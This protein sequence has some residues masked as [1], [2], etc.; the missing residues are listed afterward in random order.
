MTLEKEHD[1]MRFTT[2][3][4]PYIEGSLVT[5]PPPYETPDYRVEE[6]I[7][8]PK[9]TYFYA[10]KQRPYRLSPH[11]KTTTRWY[12][13]NMNFAGCYCTTVYKRLIPL[14]GCAVI[15]TRHILTTATSTHLILKDRYDYETLENI[16][17][18]WYDT[19][20]DNFNSSMYLSPARIHYHPLWHRP[21]HV[22]RSH[23]FS[24]TFDLAVWAATYNVYGWYFMKG[25]TTTCLRASSHSR[26]HGSPIPSNEL[27]IIVGYQYMWA[28]KHKPMPWFKYAILTRYTTSPCPKTE[29][30]WFICLYGDWARYGIEGG[31]ALHRS[32]QGRSWRHDG[33]VAMGAFSMRLRSIE[34]TH[35]FTILDNWAVLD[36]LYDAYESSFPYAW[37]DGRF[38]DT[39]HYAPV[40]KSGF[41]VPRRYPQGEEHLYVPET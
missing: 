22:N 39:K 15:T 28:F 13:D 29:W 31:A 32:F 26:D 24:F 2:T 34:M 18:A 14:A 41:Y 9:R 7:F 30:G 38:E 1:P 37:L 17:G 40:V 3:M 12:K 10:E 27:F 36:F 5:V 25:S 33:L 19:T 11:Y 8:L 21:E 35:Y 16:L 23:P 20:L 4:T 6:P